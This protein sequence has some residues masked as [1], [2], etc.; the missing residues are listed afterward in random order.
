MNKPIALI[1]GCS[2]GFG[3]L[4]TLELARHGYLVVATM[5]DLARR[6]PLDQAVN[7]AGL[8]EYV[9]VRQLD[10]AEPATHASFVAAIEADYGRIDLLVNNAGFAMAGFAEDVTLDE[11]RRQF[12]T[13]FFGTVSLTKTVLPTMRRQRAGRILMLS[14]I[15][16]RSAA[17]GISSYCSSKF[18]LEG[19]TESLRLEM[20]PLGIHCVLIEPGSFETAIWYRK[21][22]VA[23]AADSPTS[24]NLQRTATFRNYIMKGLQRRDPAEVARLIARVAAMPRPRLRYAIGPDAKSLLVLRAL[25]PF[26]L[27]ERIVVGKLQLGG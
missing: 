21:E 11:L 10:V 15:A 3:L 8:M 12:E 6:D 14:S 4:T 18:A 25:L 22:N 20:S 5:R 24:P 26:N 9:S 27:F 7:A 13:N 17:P 16:G 23:A 2:S 19:Y 1:T